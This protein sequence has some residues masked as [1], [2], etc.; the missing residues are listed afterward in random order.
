[1][2]PTH[3]VLELSVL[4]CDRVMIDPTVNSFVFNTLFVLLAARVGF[5]SPGRPPWLPFALESRR[6][7]LVDS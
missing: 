6:W 3:L 2:Q 7:Q 4:I 5:E 1:M